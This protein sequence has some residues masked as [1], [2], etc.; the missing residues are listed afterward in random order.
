MRAVVGIALLF[1]CSLLALAQGTPPGVYLQSQQNQ[2]EQ[3][4]RQS[5]GG[6]PPVPQSSTMQQMTSMIK[7]EMN[8]A[9]NGESYPSVDKWRPLTTREKFDFFLHHTYS[10]NTFAAAGVDALKGTVMKHNPEYERGFTGLGQRYG[11]NLGTSETEV[12]FERFLVPS[13]LKQDPRYFRN[14]SLPFV[15]RALYSMSRVLITRADNGGETA[16][17]SRI[18]GAAASQALSDLYVPGGVQGMHPILGRVSFD[19]VRDA[20]FNLI[21]E[22]WPDLRRKILHR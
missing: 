19:L 4:A 14:P 5:E 1:C 20:G 13:I 6:S 12:F 17:A 3:A 9:I 2:S 22:F 7:R 18:L 10:P 21:H 11:V 16:N 8:K 15:S